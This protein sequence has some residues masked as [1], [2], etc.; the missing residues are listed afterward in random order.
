MDVFDFAEDWVCEGEPDMATFL[1][2]HEQEEIIFGKFKNRKP[3]NQ[4]LD[5]RNYRP[6]C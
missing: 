4:V 5:S 2:I 1:L 6:R 3:S